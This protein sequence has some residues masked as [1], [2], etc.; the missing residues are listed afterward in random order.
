MR[1]RSH[2]LPET[3]R[4]QKTD[5]KNEVSVRFVSAVNHHAHNISIT[6]RF[7][8]LARDLPDTPWLNEADA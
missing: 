6:A 2:K 1:N 7:V 3:L 5:Y 4:G 8:S